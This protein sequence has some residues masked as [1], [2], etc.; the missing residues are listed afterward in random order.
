MKQITKQHEKCKVPRMIKSTI[1]KNLKFYQ[2]Y[3]KS[4]NETD[5]KKM[6]R[7]TVAGLKNHQSRETWRINR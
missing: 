3:R 5:N 6:D 2:N 1:N 7:E 4:K